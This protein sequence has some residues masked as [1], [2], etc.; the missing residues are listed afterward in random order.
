MQNKENDDINTEQKKKSEKKQ[1]KHALIFEGIMF[2][3]LVA[4]IIFK[5]V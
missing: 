1:I 2:I 3:L 4:Y 5:L